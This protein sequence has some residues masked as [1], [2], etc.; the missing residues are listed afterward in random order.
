[1][2]AGKAVRPLSHLVL[3]FTSPD[4]RT[5]FL[6]IHRG[7]AT[8]TLQRDDDDDAITMGVGGKI[9][10]VSSESLGAPRGFVVPVYPWEKPPQHPSNA[11]TASPLVHI[12]LRHV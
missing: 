10:S 9:V 4:D 6:A 5:G 12:P 11:L 2:K 1:M 7:C 3:A 8:A